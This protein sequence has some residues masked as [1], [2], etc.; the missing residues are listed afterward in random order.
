MH[1]IFSLNLSCCLLFF[2]NYYFIC[3]CQCLEFMY[4]SLPNPLS[5]WHRI[6]SFISPA[7][8]ICGVETANHTR[9]CPVN[10]CRECQA[11]LKLHTIQNMSRRAAVLKKS[12]IDGFSSMLP[13]LFV[14]F[15]F[16]TPIPSFSVFSQSLHLKFT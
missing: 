6:H 11:N 8:S 10:K 4:H 16:N 9:H 2:T 14:R 5:L 13:Y 3:F 1:F 7:L 12:Q 15:S